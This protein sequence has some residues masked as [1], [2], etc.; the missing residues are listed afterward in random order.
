LARHELHARLDA[1]CED[2]FSSNQ[3]KWA[4]ACPMD[5]HRP[6]DHMGETQDRATRLKL[7]RLRVELAKSD[8]DVAEGESIG[9]SAALK[10][11]GLHREMLRS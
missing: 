2:L 9:L 10:H 3:L 4:D 5:E 6:A 7:L 1:F 11:R 8:A